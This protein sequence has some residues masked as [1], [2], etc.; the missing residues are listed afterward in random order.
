M[1]FPVH[2]P[3]FAGARK[4]ELP[5]Q[6]INRVCVCVCEGSGHALQLLTINCVISFFDAVR[7]L[8]TAESI[9]RSNVAVFSFV[10]FNT[11]KYMYTVRVGV[12]RAGIRFDALNDVGGLWRRS[13]CDAFTRSVYPLI[14]DCLLN[15]GTYCELEN[16]AKGRNAHDNDTHTY[17]IKF[18]HTHTHSENGTEKRNEKSKQKDGISV[19]PLAQ[20]LVFSNWMR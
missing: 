17:T 3:R 13:A 6:P 16:D 11:I 12:G 4:R 20:M 10:T 18:T 2:L 15:N 1:L 14:N 5:H 19:L 9:F 7:K 8:F